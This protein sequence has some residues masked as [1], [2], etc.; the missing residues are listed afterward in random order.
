AET[1][2]FAGHEGVEDLAS[3][4]L[5]FANGGAGQLVSIWHNVL[6][7]PSGRLLELFFENGYFTVQDDFFGSIRYQTGA[8]PEAVEVPEDEVRRRYLEIVGLE[9]D[10]FDSAL[11]KYS[12]ADYFFLRALAEE[13]DPFP[14]FDVGLRAHELVDAVY[15]SAAEGGSSVRA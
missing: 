7:R 2:N 4:S 15:R 11:S 6:D 9:S 12:L 13:R 1:R 10:V 5:R 14:G 3:V 8:T